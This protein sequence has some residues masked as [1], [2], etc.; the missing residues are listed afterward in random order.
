METCPC[1][2]HVFYT[3]AQFSSSVIY[4]IFLVLA[5]VLLSLCNR[6]LNYASVIDFSIKYLL[7]TVRTIRANALTKNIPYNDL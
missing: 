6:T 4:T 7:V 2:A 3:S 1:M 5:F